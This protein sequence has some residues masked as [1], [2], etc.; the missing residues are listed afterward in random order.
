MKDAAAL[1]R[2]F[3]DLLG[4]CAV[5]EGPVEALPVGASEMVARRSWTPYSC[6]LRGTGSGVIRF[7]CPVVVLVCSCSRRT[8]RSRLSTRR[9]RLFW[10]LSSCFAPGHLAVGQNRLSQGRVGWNQLPGALENGDGYAYQY[11]ARALALFQL[12]IQV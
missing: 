12:L 2:A 1:D 9:G 5:A 8:S 10:A 6:K 4:A 7:G 3:K 11:S